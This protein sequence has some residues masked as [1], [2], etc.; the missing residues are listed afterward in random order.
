MHIH[1]TVPYTHA[2]YMSKSRDVSCST[3]IL[4]SYIMHMSNQAVFIHLMGSINI[5]DITI[6]ST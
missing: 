2:V 5:R 4:I 3:E 6:M 1:L